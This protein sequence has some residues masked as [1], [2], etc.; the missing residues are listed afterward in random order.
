MQPLDAY[1][2]PHDQ[3]PF[4]PAPH[5]VA[6]RYCPGDGRCGVTSCA[7][8]LPVSSTSGD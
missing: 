4:A 5:E 3:D 8:G 7:H 2:L 6:A 1:Y